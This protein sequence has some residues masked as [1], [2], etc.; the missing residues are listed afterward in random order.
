MRTMRISPK[1][2]VFKQKVRESCKQCKNYGFKA[3]CPP[4]IADIS[5][6]EKLLK[7]YKYCVLC[8]D[9]FEAEQENWKECGKNSSLAIHK[10]IL[11][12]Q[13]GLI[14]AG[15]YFY[16]LFGAGSCKLCDNCTIPCRNPQNS[17]IPL[18]GTGIDVVETMKKYGVNIKFPVNSNFYR[19]GAIFYD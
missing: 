14:R 16:A 17:L 7:S 4:Y 15:Y 6:Y 3:T 8:F 11:K 10:F 9:I 13:K 19:I 12:R 18:E 1:N 2:L 5:Y